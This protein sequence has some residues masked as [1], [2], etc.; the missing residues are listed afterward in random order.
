M[1]FDGACMVPPWCFLSRCFHGT[2]TRSASV[3]VPW[4][5]RFHGASMDSQ[6]ASIVLS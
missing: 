3:V 1:R 6:G 2:L 4:C 5:M